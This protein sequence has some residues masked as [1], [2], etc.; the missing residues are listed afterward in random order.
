[1]ALQT[2]TRVREFGWSET[3]MNRVPPD[4]VLTTIGKGAFGTI[5]FLPTKPAGSQT[6]PVTA[7]VCERDPIN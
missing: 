3:P 6:Q 5:C 4:I 1:M 7:K 2:Q